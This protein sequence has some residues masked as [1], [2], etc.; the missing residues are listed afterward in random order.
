MP[1]LV[2]LLLP[3]APVALVGDTPKCEYTCWLQDASM[4]G[5]VLA[6]NVGALCSFVRSTFSVN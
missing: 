4:L 3:G 1:L 2:P 5:H 6:L